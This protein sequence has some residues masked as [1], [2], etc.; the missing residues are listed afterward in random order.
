M[1]FKLFAYRIQCSIYC[2]CKHAPVPQECSSTETKSITSL[3]LITLGTSSV[4]WILFVSQALFIFCEENKRK[5]K[6]CTHTHTHK[7]EIFLQLVFLTKWISTIFQ[8]QVSFYCQ[9]S[10]SVDL[11]EHIRMM[12]QGCFFFFLKKFYNFCGKL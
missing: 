12:L 5:Q 11:P 3:L 1:S 2:M 7:R 10:I 8:T 6:K 4:D 9:T